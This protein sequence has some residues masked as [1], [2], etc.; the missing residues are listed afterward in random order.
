VN[1][2]EFTKKINEQSLN[3]LSSSMIKEKNKKKKGTELEHLILGSALLSSITTLPL[4]LPKA[5]KLLIKLLLFIHLN[6]LSLSQVH[7]LYFGF[8]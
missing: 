2:L 8:L 1:K 3:I 4:T 5:W 7:Q 6:T